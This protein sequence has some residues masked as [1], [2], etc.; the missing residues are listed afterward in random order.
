VAEEEPDVEA[1]L[2]ELRHTVESRRQQGLYPAGLEEDLAGHFR[3]IVRQRVTPDLS[4]LDAAM[5]RLRGVPGLSSGRIPL[6]SEV[7]GGSAM[8]RTLARLAGRQ[9]QGILEQVEELADALR[10]V[11]DELS[12]AVRQASTHVHADLIGQIDALQERLSALERQ[13]LD[14]PSPAAAL[15]ELSRRLERL[16][17]KEAARQFRPPYSAADFEA[18]FRGGEDELKA[19]Y[20]DL[21]RRLDGCSPVLDIGCGRGEFMEL[22]AE[23][24]VESSGVEL[25]TELAAAGS[26]RDLDI[27][28]GDGLAHLAELPDGS[29]GGLS[30]IQVIE[31]LSPNQVSELT[32]LAA[33]KLR[34]GGRAVIE[35]VNPQSLYVFARAFYLD[36]THQNP[37]HPAYLTFLFRRAGFQGLEID[38]RSEPS[39]DESLRPVGTADVDENFSRINQILFGPQDYALIATR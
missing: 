18:T 31:H 19:R 37:V 34:P 28:G 11:A 27:T 33:D 6:D 15:A 24:G 4:R 10:S 17:S 5:Q 13:P 22:L 21:A 35:T 36:P 32:S 25:D 12:W 1:L 14:D 26:D 2:E 3:R 38:W 39:A 16:E 23:I 9:T 8:H 29:L 30:L 20:R 7:P